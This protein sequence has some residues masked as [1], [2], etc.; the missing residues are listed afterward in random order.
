MICGHARG[1]RRMRTIPPNSTTTSDFNTNTTAQRYPASTTRIRITTTTG[2]KKLS[3]RHCIQWAINRPF[4]RYERIVTNPAAAT[5]VAN[6]L[7]PRSHRTLR[8]LC[9]R[10]RQPPYGTESEPDME[11]ERRRP[12]TATAD[13]GTFQLFRQCSAS[14]KSVLADS[15]QQLWSVRKLGTNREPGTRL[16]TLPAVPP[17]CLF[18]KIPF[19][20]WTMFHTLYYDFLSKFF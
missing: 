10:Q 19:Q 14:L 15:K 16:G 13:P 8:R 12:T 1:Q 6:K 11:M 2:A 3:G 18:S 7:L 4:S 17:F 20:L 5:S 9:E